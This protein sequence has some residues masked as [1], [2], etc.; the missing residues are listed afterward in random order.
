[1][2]QKV[3]VVYQITFKAFFFSYFICFLS[4]V[5]LDSPI[6]YCAWVCFVGLRGGTFKMF[7]VLFCFINTKH[8]KKKEDDATLVVQNITA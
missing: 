8:V 3:A 7:Y 5:A 6:I 1:M 4:A 2:F